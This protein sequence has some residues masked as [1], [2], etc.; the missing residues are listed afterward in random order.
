MS[1][2]RDILNEK[3]GLLRV[4]EYSHSK[5]GNVFWKCSCDCGGEKTVR[6]DNLN[7]GATQTCGCK[8]LFDLRKIKFGLT[9]VNQRYFN[10]VKNDSVKRN[11]KFNLTIEYLQKVFDEQNNKCSLSDLEI[12]FSD[13]YKKISQ[14]ASLDRIDSSVGYIEGNV[15]WV[16]KYINQM[17]HRLPQEIFI[18]LCQAVSKKTKM[19]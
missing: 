19:N 6:A 12:E 1:K 10:K 16:H 5:N 7:S 8:N 2:R 14:T 18:Q 17:K 11:L 9:L 4:T 15:Q 3:F 13:D